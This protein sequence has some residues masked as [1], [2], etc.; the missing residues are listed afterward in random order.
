M[1]LSDNLRGALYMNVAM[2]AFT[3]NDAAM[4]AAL[5]D[6]P[7]WQA[8]AMRGLVTLG[9][10]LLVA[11]LS[12][13]IRLSMGPKDR[14]VVAIRCFAEVASTLLFLAA[15]VHM[16]IANLSAILQALPLAV[17][18]AAAVFFGE[19][20]GWRRMSAILVGFAGVLIIIRPGPSG[21]DIWSLMGLASMAFVVLRDLST[22]KLSRAVPSATVAIL[23][24]VAV[25][26]T[27][28]ALTP[29]TGWVMPTGRDILLILAAATC[30]VAGYNFAVMVMRVGDVGF[31]APFRYTSLLWAI[32]LGWLVFGTLPDA[33]TLFGAALVV[34]SGIFT[35]VRERRLA[36][37]A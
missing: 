1:P 19:R 29:L 31:V 10:L 32:V 15:L 22:R 12:G 17:T 11:H 28:L 2:A 6:L 16:P 34:G 8:I 9:P 27:A 14:G 26:V 23:A 33:L 21:F 5:Q 37:A 20:V 36:K 24:S 35:L 30:L 4:K 7:L 13:G 18:L 3:L 25:T